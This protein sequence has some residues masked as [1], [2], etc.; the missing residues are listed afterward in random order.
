MESQTNST[1][2]K[3]PAN[4]RC[5]RSSV[6]RNQTTHDVS[7]LNP[8]GRVNTDNCT[9]KTSHRLLSCKRAFSISTFNTRTLRKENHLDEIFY[10]A[11]EHNLGIVAIQE[12]RHVHEEEVI[13]QWNHTPNHT[14]FTSSALKNQAGAAIH[15]IGLLMRKDVKDDLESITAIGDIIGN[16]GNY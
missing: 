7:A 10:S 6:S 9:S 2:V 14:L 5:H 4:S 15:G 12:H 13:K 3:A 8:T 16:F 1:R 11:E